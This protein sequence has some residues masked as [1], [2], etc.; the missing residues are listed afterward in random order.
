[1]IKKKKVD[2]SRRDM[3]TR[4]TLGRGRWP[5]GWPGGLV[6]NTLLSVLILEELIKHYTQFPGVSLEATS[7]PEFSDLLNITAFM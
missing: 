4:V 2:K 3:K 1:M 5:L 6:G 7:L